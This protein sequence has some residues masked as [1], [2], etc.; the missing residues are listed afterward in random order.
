[1]Q[2]KKKRKNNL[3]FEKKFSMLGIFAEVFADPHFLSAFLQTIIVIFIGFLFMRKGYVNVYG[4]KTLSALIW[5]L[6]VPC[7]AFNAFMQDFEWE[8]FKSS[9]VEFFLAVFFYIFLIVI[10]KLLFIKKGEKVST[11]SALFMA[12]GQTTLFSM[13]ILQSVYEG[14]EEVMLYIS[15][16]S[17]V[18]RIFVYIIGISIISGEKI[19]FA[20]LGVSLRK[21]FVTPVMIGMFLGLF[22]FLSQNAMPQIFVGEKSYSVLR[23]DKSLPV[24]YATVRSV[25]RLVS[26]LCM[27]MIGMSIGKAKLSESLTDLFAWKIALLRNIAGP[28]LVALVCLLIHGTGLYHFNEYSLMAILIGFSAPVS[29]SLSI[30]CVEHHCEESLASR[31]CVISTLLTLVTFPSAFVLGKIALKIIA[32]MS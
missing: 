13:P 4:E 24:L 23:I 19:S 31:S 28:V 8:I 10:G 20:N 9:I 27:F 2:I 6:A 26:P 29:V 30:A 11:V 7:F 14:Q 18:F 5:K 16:I 12:I 32:Y 25:S 15:T 22:V 3:I 1:M 21:V 17:I